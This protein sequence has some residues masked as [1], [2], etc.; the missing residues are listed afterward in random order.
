MTTHD[1]GNMSPADP[2]WQYLA[3][4]IFPQLGCLY[5]HGIRVYRL[6][7]SNAVYRYEET[8]TGAAFIGKFFYN[9]HCRDWDTAGRRMEREYGNL[10]YARSLG[11]D[12]YP[13][14]VAR[15]L[16]RNGARG[17]FLAV[18]ICPGR[19]LDH[20]LNAVIRGGDPDRLYRRLTALGYFLAT[21]HN[22]S[23]APG[24]LDFT[25]NIHHFESLLNDLRCDGI[26]GP[27][28]EQRFRERSGA[29]YY[30]SCMWEDAPVLVHGDATPSNLCFGEHLQV[31]SFDLER[32]HRT[33]RVYDLGLLAGELKHFF[34]RGT[35]NRYAAE[36]FTGHLLWEYA[37]HFPDR[38]AAFRAITRRLPYY[39]ALSLLRIARNHYL[40]I[41]YR[42]Q[43]ISEA[44]ESL[45]G[46]PS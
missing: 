28:E 43:L 24:R 34:L 26:M 12:G 42:R 6:N 14:C 27:G 35:G 8:A 32:A 23:A 36:P 39:Q 22:R 44:G 40:P 29:W 25:A 9:D 19:A 11:L 3:N 18:E 16:G 37:C 15:P 21:L 1:S 38:E 31:Y 17:Q 45:K 10:L 2:L 33:D 30:H 5:V 7:A 13:H 20:Y 41:P 46:L 4:E